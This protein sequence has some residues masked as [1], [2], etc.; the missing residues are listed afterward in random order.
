MEVQCATHMARFGHD[1][2]M[3]LLGEDP[4]LGQH[5]GCEAFDCGNAVWIKHMLTVHK[6]TKAPDPD[7]DCEKCGHH[8]RSHIGPQGVY[9]RGSIECG[10]TFVRNIMRKYPEVTIKWVD[11]ELN[12]D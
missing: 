3:R 4:R 7:A 6:S 9:E 10:C 2:K 12:H 5:W 1:R 8:D 11:G